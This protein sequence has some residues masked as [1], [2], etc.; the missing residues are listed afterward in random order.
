MISPTSRMMVK[1]PPFVSSNHLPMGGCA[2]VAAALSTRA[3]IR[4][5]R[6][7]ATMK[8]QISEVVVLNIRPALSAFEA[9]AADTAPVAAIPMPPPQHL[10]L[11]STRLRNLQLTKQV[12]SSIPMACHGPTR[13]VA[14]DPSSGRGSCNW[15]ISTGKGTIFLF[16]SAA[17]RPACTRHNLASGTRESVECLWS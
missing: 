7:N 14:R 2:C 11:L 5:N 17:Y 15:V 9:M 13:V 4:R 3:P 6:T 12:N 8:G 16:S 1:S 10:C